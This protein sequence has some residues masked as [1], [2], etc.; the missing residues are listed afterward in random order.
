MKRYEQRYFV[1]IVGLLVATGQND[2]TGLLCLIGRTSNHDF[3]LLLSEIA[4]NRKVAQ[5]CCEDCFYYL[6]VE[7]HINNFTEVQKRG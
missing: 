5:Q 4:L 7:G 3:Y 1:D 6:L 2:V